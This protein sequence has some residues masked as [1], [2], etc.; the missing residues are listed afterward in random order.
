M[1]TEKNFW[2]H[3]LLKVPNFTTVVDSVEHSPSWGANRLS[4]IQEIPW[5]LFNPK[6]HVRIHK[7]P[8]PVPI[9]SQI[10]MLPHPWHLATLDKLSSIYIHN[11]DI[12]WEASDI[13]M[14]PDDGNDLL[15]HAG[16]KLGTYQ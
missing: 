3:S 7:H 14:P 11:T 9:L 13:T 10:K 5:I 15:K 6:I 1:Y 12:V 16:V 4:A 8:Q 2:L